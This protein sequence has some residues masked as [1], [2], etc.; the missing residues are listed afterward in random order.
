MGCVRNFKSDSSSED[1]EVNRIISD[2]GCGALGSLQ[3]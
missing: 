1:L 2:V 3:R